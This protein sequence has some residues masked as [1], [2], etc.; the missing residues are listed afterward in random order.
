M[1]QPLD[2]LYFTWL[3]SQVA[4]TRIKNP[5]RTYW[6]MLKVLFTTEFVWYVPND[7]N[8][9]EDGRDLRCEFADRERL[10]DIDSSW[11]NLGCSMFELLI[12]LS[13]RLSFEA[14]GESRVWFWEMIDNLGLRGFTDHASFKD[15]FVRDILNVVIFRT[16]SSTGEGG[17]FPLQKEC[18]DQRR[19][20]IWY[21]MS[22]YVL[23]RN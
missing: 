4:D 5:A 17:L 15:E 21:Q 8:R 6:R 11:M 7:D 9:M 3:Y 20:E 18:V 10:K 12:A 19:V 14:E 1:S 16:Y 22:A 23:E 13:R 2:E